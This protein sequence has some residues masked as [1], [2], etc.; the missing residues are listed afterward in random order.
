MT[1][2]LV[3]VLSF[4]SLIFV[5]LLHRLLKKNLMQASSVVFWIVFGIFIITIPLLF[6][7]YKFVALNLFGLADT[8]VLIFLIIISFLSFYM[9][10][11]SSKIKALTDKVQMLI[12]YVAIMENKIS[13]IDNE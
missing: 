4:S 3:L 10:Y 8:T 2:K 1:I 7:L 5:C 6:P 9:V 13:K 12:T 11:L